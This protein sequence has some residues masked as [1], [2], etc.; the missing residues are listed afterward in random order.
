MN[1]EWGEHLEE[2][3]RRLIS[4]LVVFTVAAFSAFFFSDRAAAFLL[5]PVAE[6]NVRL[7]TFSPAEK[8]LAYLRLALW[9][10]ALAASPFALLQIGL[11]IWP[12]LR[13]HER[14]W[15]LAALSIIPVLFTAGAALAYRFL[16]P[17]VLRFFLLF[18]AADGIAPV[19]GFKDYLALLF[20]LMLAAGL[21][22][23]TPL[24]LLVLFAAGIVSPTAA[25]RRRPH[26][27][28]LIF[29]TAALCT[30]PDVISQLALGIPL[31]LLFELTLLLGR[32]LVQRK[33][34]TQP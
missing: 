8:F 12:A 9:T 32:L 25:A 16:S 5:A 23:Q 29:L 14:K 15:T 10:G 18:A 30:P 22:L 2:L 20:S 17:A 24:L 33:N 1:G 34:I 28:L 27:A 3:R 11:F 31:Y 13:Q 26:I 21:L 4:V 6:L 19:W 7:Y